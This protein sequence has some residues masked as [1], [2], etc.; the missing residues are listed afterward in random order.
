MYV[1]I[2][3]A[4]DGSLKSSE[5]VYPTEVLADAAAK[6]RSSVNNCR[7]WIMQFPDPRPVSND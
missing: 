3:E 2:Y 5:S 4:K 7:A 6:L 1:V